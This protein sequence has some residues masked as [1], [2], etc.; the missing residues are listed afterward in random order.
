[1][2]LDATLH[3][4][5]SGLDSV[6]RR[7]ALVSH[8]VANAGTPGYVKQRADTAAAGQGLGVL[9]G[10]ARREVDERLQADLFAAQADAGA[11]DTRAAALAAIDAAQGVPG[12]G[13]SLPELLG[14]LRDGFSV[15]LRDPTNG[16]QQRA[17]V[18][19]AEGLAGGVN[20]LAETVTSQRQAAQDALV[21]DVATLNGAL[22]DLGD[23]SDEIVKATAAGSSTADL[24]T[25]RDGKMQQVAALTG[26]RFL[27]Q[28]NGDVL[29]MAG[30]ALLPL[31]AE[32][33]P[34]GVAPATLRPQ[35]AA[36]DTPGLTLNGQDVT[37]RFTEGRIGAN[38]ALRDRV[39]PTVQAELDEFA[40]ALARGFDEQGLRLFAGGDAAASPAAPD[41]AAERVGFAQALRVNPAVAARPSL[42]RDGTPAPAAPG[43][44]GYS[45]KIQRVLDTVLG[46]APPAVQ[47]AGLGVDG[48][49]AARFDAPPT[50]A[51]FAATLA[52]T[53][54]EAT[55]SAA[56]RADTAQAVQTA[57]QGRFDQETGVSV[58]EEMASMVQLQN[59]YA[60]NARVIAASQAMW[61][62]LLDT[63]RP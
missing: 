49:L 30:N 59:A 1:M 38:L 23:L 41:T 16:A 50:L 22:R 42:V 39:L 55:A 37:A 44:A 31:R 62:R 7:L 14:T 27:H 54:A 35:T 15:L 25:R 13:G 26:A 33:G 19:A 5:S 24:Q 47:T 4:A 36:S 45:A 60:A 63:V 6:N 10:P 34:F 56:A 8:N 18:S 48:G 53:N 28:P 51:A 17:V 12:G 46:D 52:A 61:E 58:D 32:Q 40:S 3:V 43:P 29:A 11:L 9:T 57:L 20:A 21:S 2:S